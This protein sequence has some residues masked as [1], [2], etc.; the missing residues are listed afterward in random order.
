M[1]L[2]GALKDYDGANLRFSDDL[3]AALDH[4]DQIY[5]GI[6]KAIDAFIAENKIEAPPPSVY[7]PV[8]QPETITTSLDLAASGI[9]SIVWCIGFSPDFRWVDAGV[10]NGMGQPQHQR[11]VT[12]EPGLY[13][14]GLPWLHTWGSGRFSGIKRDS[15]HIADE[16]E[17]LERGNQ[18]S[19]TMAKAV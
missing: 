1:Q 19:R 2:Y 11:G 12:S 10:F 4:A 17:A 18:T 14:L 16:I 7:T 13:F 9:T 8:W 15:L 5:N 6:N 3:K